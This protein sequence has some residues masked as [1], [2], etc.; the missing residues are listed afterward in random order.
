MGSERVRPDN[1]ENDNDDDSNGDAFNND[2]AFNDANREVMELYLR[3]KYC[4]YVIE[5][6]NYDTS[7]SSST[8]QPRPSPLPSPPSTYRVT[9]QDMFMRRKGGGGES[10]EIDKG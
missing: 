8:P 1:N 5:L 4:Y 9:S 7:I 6:I 10:K 3:I 2:K